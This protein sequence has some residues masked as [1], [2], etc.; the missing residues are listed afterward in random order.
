[1][2]D[3]EKAALKI[4]NRYPHLHVTVFDAKAGRHKLIEQVKAN[5]VPNKDRVAEGNAAARGKTDVA[6]RKH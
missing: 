5:S 4:K 2:E 6:G 1:M 3:A